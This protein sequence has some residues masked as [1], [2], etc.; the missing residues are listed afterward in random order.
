MSA[1]L[2]LGWPAAAASSDIFHDMRPLKPARALD[3]ISA[4]YFSCSSYALAARA[5]R[6]PH[7]LRRASAAD[8]YYLL[9]GLR[10]DSMATFFCTTTLSGF[11]RKV[12]A[13]ISTGLLLRAHD[14]EAAKR[15]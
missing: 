13:T 11:R 1:G 3:F 8:S 15:A 2:T 12:R 6:S 9:S 10:L 7:A 4:R 5:E 14:A